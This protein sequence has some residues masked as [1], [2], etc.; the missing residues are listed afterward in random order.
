MRL[1]VIRIEAS[2]QQA[3]KS[4]GVRLLVQQHGFT[5]VELITII[6]I[7][8]I[9]AV[10]AAPRFF[11]STVFESRGFYNQV[12]STLR[13]AQKTAIAQRRFVCVQFS[14]INVIPG[15]VTLSTGLD[16][17]CG[18]PLLGPS[19][20]P[21]SNSKASFSAT[22]ADLSFDC[23]GRPRSVGAAV[24]CNSTAGILAAATPISVN[25]YVTAITVEREPGYV[26]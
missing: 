23:L 18:T 24:A 14:A 20:Q 3:G 25:G 26:H 16:N 12:I 13:Y 9:L 7:V 6:M 10:A 2:K 5:L 21:L 22:Y 19:G 15:T 1:N 4:C 8:G 11:D 17:S